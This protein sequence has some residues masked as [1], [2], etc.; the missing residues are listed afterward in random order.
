[1]R[2]GFTRWMAEN[3]PWIAVPVLVTIATLGF[4]I[5]A[6]GDARDGGYTLY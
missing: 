4:L 5:F 2:D 6:G 1:M 3:W